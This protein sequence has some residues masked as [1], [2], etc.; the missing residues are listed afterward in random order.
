MEIKNVIN[1]LKSIGYDVV[2]IENA[3]DA[4][5]TII[6]KIDKKDLIAFGGST[7]LTQLGIVEHI[8]NNDYNVLNRYQ[9]NLSS[10]E[11]YEIERKSLL[12]DLFITSTNAIASTGE[13]V[14]IDGKNNRV[15][16]Q[17]FGPKKVFIVT[18]VNKICDSLELSMERVQNYAAPLNAK[19]FEGK[20]NTGCMV[21][22]EC[23]SCISES[24]ICKT[25]VTIR[26]PARKG[27]T[28]IFLINE[29]L[30]F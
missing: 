4:L 3:H 7:T 18:G 27:R 24:T 5:K 9:P 10:D 26:R 15:S 14:N 30:G 17:I 25:I 23:R 20:I 19:R 16:A 11:I 6:S 8:L 21:D 2:Y 13:L 12:C 1:K 29:N 28:T 22:G